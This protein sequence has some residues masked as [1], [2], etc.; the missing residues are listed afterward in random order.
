MLTSQ[1][2]CSNDSLTQHHVPSILP[3]SLQLP[4]FCMIALAALRSLWR[5]RHG[6]CA[7]NA[8]YLH[9]TACTVFWLGLQDDD[10]EEGQ[11]DYLS[12]PHAMLP[13]SAAPPSGRGR[14]RYDIDDSMEGLQT[15]TAVCQ[16][17]QPS[18]ARL[19]AHHAWTESPTPTAQY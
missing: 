14:A 17:W 6:M 3:P 8:H 19:P 13:S 7:C 1:L 9:M 2:L 11:N 12:S 4:G 10:A 18:Q 5:L 15:A 16:P